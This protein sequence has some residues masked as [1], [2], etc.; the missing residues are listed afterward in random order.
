[1]KRCWQTKGGDAENLVVLDKRHVEDALGMFE[2]IIEQ[3]ELH[4]KERRH[5]VT[6][7][8]QRRPGLVDLRV[9]NRFL[10]QVMVGYVETEPSSSLSDMFLL[11][12]AGREDN[13]HIVGEP[14]TIGLTE[15]RG[16]KR[17]SRHTTVIF[18][19]SFVCTLAG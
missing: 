3:L 1:M 17:K 6:V 13:G 9:W 7:F 4:V 5:V 18:S 2:A 10:L 16:W 15:V 19:V 11:Q 8:R 14:D 12:Y